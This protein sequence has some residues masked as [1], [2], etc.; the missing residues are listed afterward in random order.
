MAKKS[1]I[2]NNNLDNPKG[3]LAQLT[4]GQLDRV[5]AAKRYELAYHKVFCTSQSWRQEVITN[6]ITSPNDR[7]ISEFV[8]EVIQLAES[9]GEIF[10]M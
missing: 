5:K 10:P 3:I 6:P 2:L 7:I 1:K 9:E 4:S 8:K